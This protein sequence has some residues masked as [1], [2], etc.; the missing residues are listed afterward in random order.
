MS[1]YL[2]KASR[3]H[4]V[5][6]VALFVF[7]LPTALS[8]FTSERPAARSIPFIVTKEQAEKYLSAA[9]SVS[10][11]LYVTLKS[12]TRFVA[13]TREADREIL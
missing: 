2:L 1:W 11:L 7:G 4:L 6:A 9:L 13:I 3:A 5:L 12:R 8:V 10:L